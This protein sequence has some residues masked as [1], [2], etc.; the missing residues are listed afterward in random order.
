M[1]VISLPGF[2]LFAHSILKRW[3]T[4]G[5]FVSYMKSG[6][7]NPFPVTNF[8][9]NVELVYL[10]RIYADNMVTKLAANGVVCQKRPR[11]YRKRVRNI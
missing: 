1:R 4:G 9:Q 7:L 3:L 8:R 5:M 11:L 6:S 10:L 2:D